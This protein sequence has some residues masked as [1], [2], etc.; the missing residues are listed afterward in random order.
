MARRCSKAIR[1]SH[2]SAPASG[3]KS[4]YVPVA[5]VARPTDRRASRVFSPVRDGWANRRSGPRRPTL[6]ADHHERPQN[7]SC[8]HDNRAI[9]TGRRRVGAGWLQLGPAAPP[10]VVG[11]PSSGRTG[12]R[13][14]PPRIFHRNAAAAHRR[15][16]RH[17]VGHGRGALA[18]LSDRSTSRRR[19]P[20]PAVSSHADRVT[21]RDASTGALTLRR[22]LRSA[23]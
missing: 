16:T 6:R 14:R 19:T 18:E 12:H 10:G 9:R 23:A 3:A 11:E 8:P 13:P 22:I 2:E 1:S 7:G 4:D 20:I 15:R 5:G 17:G 21:V